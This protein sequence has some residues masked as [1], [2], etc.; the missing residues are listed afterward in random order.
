MDKLL[1]ALRDHVSDRAARRSSPKTKAEPVVAKIE[2]AQDASESSETEKSAEKPKRGR[3]PKVTK[4]KE[5][6]FF[7]F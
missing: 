5:V 3:K 4:V 1:K 2:P 6:I 7:Y